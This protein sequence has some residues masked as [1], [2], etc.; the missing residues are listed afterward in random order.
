MK[1]NAMNNPGQYL[2]SIREQRKLGVKAVYMQTG[3]GD[4][5]IRRIEEGKTKFPPAPQLKALA[6]FYNINV[7]NLYKAYGYLDDSDINFE[8]VTFENTEFLDE[9][10]YS[11]IQGLINLLAEKR[12][13]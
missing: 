5:T 6:N 2:K 13:K 7:I 9:E 4:S 3:V 8:N 11:S 1:E 10:S 12:T